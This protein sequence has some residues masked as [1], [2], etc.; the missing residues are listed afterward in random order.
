MLLVSARSQAVRYADCAQQA[1]GNRA[2][3][4]AET[5]LAESV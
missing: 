1:A 3:Q 5:M 4:E 2:V